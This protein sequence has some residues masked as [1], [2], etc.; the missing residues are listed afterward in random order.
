MLHEPLHPALVGKFKAEAGLSG[1]G[2]YHGIPPLVAAAPVSF[3]TAL[4]RGRAR[5]LLRT[6]MKTYQVREVV[7][8]PGVTNV[9]AD[10]LSRL[11]AS[12]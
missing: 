6:S 10:A 2:P 12:G 4:S 11:Y 8:L 5:S 9:Q 3:L 1:H 7:P